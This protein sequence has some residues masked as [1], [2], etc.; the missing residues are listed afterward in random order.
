MEQHFERVMFLLAWTCFGW[1][2]LGFKATPALKYDLFNNLTIG[3]AHAAWKVVDH[4]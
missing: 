3:Y 2:F 4:C 1:H